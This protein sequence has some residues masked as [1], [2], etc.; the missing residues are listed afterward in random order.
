MEKRILKLLKMPIYVP[1][2]QMFHHYY[3]FMVQYSIYI[4]LIYTQAAGPNVAA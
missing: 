1:L 4:N 2:I 3:L